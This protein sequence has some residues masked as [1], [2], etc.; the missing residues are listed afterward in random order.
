M[1]STT[2][3]FALNVGMNW[4]ATAVNMVVPFFLTPFVV[5]HLGTVQYGIWILAVSTVSYL[6]LLDLGLRSAVI[7]FVSK[8]EAEGNHTEGAKLIGAALWFRVLIALGVSC[9]SILLAFLMPHFFKIPASLVYASRITVL[10]CALGV[11]VT[12]ISGVFGA[13]LAAIHRFDLLSSITMGQTILRAGGVLLLLRTGHGLISLA[14]WEL[15][16]IVAVG[17]LTCLV[18]M[19][20]FPASR[21]PVRRPESSVLRAIWSY[22]F[23][24]FVFMMAVQVIINTDSLVVGA[25]LSVGMVTFYSI[26][27]SLVSYASQVSS[28]VSTTFMPMASGLDASGRHEDLRR[29]LLRGTQAMLGLVFPIALALIFRGKTFISIW[30]GPQYGVISET[31]LRILMISLFFSMADSTAGAIMMAIDKH[32]PVARWA[33]YE[34]VLN[35]GLSIILV[36]KVGLYGVA[37]GTSVS[38]VFTHLAF[39]PRYVKRILGVSSVAYMW[40]GWGKISLAAMP[41]G[42]ACYLADRC[43]HPSNLPIFFIQII[44]TLPIY[45]IGVGVMFRHEAVK[46][47]SKWRQSKLAIA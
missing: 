24:T 34:S 2:K 11:A 8:A 23:T 5:R 3:R 10:A 41:F 19:K 28:A 14:Y 45:G 30:M 15:I 1:A 17:I 36:R 35:L 38:M 27:S 33:V 4:V 16:V 26:G 21:T 39:W 43:W 18:A 22:S 25:F 37:W 40:Q 29:M 12:L 42:A 7:R 31:V 32:K 47:F 13:V 20:V 9:L 46:L 44:V 6:A